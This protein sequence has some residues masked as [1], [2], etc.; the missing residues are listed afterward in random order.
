MAGVG[1]VRELKPPYSD[2]FPKIKMW[3][4]NQAIWEP[5]SPKNSV[6]FGPEISFGHAIAEAFPEEEI[7]LVKYAVPGTALYNDWSPKDKG[8][9]YVGFMETVKTALADLDASEINYEVAGM[10]WLQ[11]ES[12][13]N[14]NKAEDYEK[15]L[16]KFIAHMRTKFKAPEMPFIIARVR[17]YYGGETGQAR[18]VRDAQVKI[19][20]AVKNVGWFDTDDCSMANEGHYNGAGLIEIGKRFAAGY[21]RIGFDSAPNHEPRTWKDSN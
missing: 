11:G 7:R 5:L 13:A 19:A 21:Q 20:G 10:L 18:I 1:N 3:N 2:P 6:S 12:D 17:A 4:R 9:Q 15:N 16:T 14:E 8:D